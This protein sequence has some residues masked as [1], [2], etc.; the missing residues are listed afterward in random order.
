VVRAYAAA[1][2]TA[3]NVR[4]VHRSLSHYLEQLE[5]LAGLVRALELA[6]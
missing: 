5:A 1:G 4:F 2:S 3:L 6:R